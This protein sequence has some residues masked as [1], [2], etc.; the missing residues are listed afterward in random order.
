MDGVY[1]SFGS[2]NGIRRVS[3]DKVDIFKKKK[4]K[5]IYSIYVAQVVFCNM[6]SCRHAA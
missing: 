4:K 6:Q 2:L 5:E 3:P 1:W